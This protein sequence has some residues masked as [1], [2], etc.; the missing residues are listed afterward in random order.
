MKLGIKQIK[1]G[2][3]VAAVIGAVAVPGAVFASRSADSVVQGVTGA[4]HENQQQLRHEDRLD[5]D[6]DNN[7]VAIAP[8]LEH[9]HNQATPPAAD[10]AVTEAQARTIAQNQMPGKTITKVERENEEGVTVFSVRFSDGSRVDVN[11]TTGAIV[12]DEDEDMA[13]NNNNVENNR[14]RDNNNSVN[15]NRGPGHA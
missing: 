6:V 11:A 3:A 10:T 9:E 4:G 14:G 8:E 2:I 5:N 13:D 12:L 7:D 1:R 15:S